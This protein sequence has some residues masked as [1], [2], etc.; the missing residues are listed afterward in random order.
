MTDHS[1]DS[2]HLLAAVVSQLPSAVVVADVAGTVV[3][4]NRQAE[5]L[6][7]HA[8]TDTVGRPVADFAI[9]PRDKD[10]PGAIVRAVLTDGSWSGA[11]DTVHA[12]G[13]GIRV[14]A[15]IAGLTDEASGFRGFTSVSAAVTALAPLDGQVARETPHDP[16]TGLPN[17][18]LF[19]DHIE[20]ALAR[21]AR[22]GQATA[23][24]VIDLDDFKDI[25]DR[26]GS[27]AA[28]RVLQQVGEV[29]VAE[30]RTGDIVARLGGDE[31]FV[32]CDGLA[33]P[34]EALHI[35]ERIQTAL[36]E[37]VDVQGS[38]P[39]LSTSVGVAASARGVRPEGM[40]RNAFAAMYSAKDV[41]RGEVALF[42]HA[43][44]EASRLRNQEVAELRAALLAGDVKTYYQPQVSLATG[45]I[46]GFEALARWTH[47]D[48][49][50]IPP[51]EFIA[52]AE[53][54]G[55]IDELGAQVLRAACAAAAAWDDASDE[56]VQVAVNVS[57]RQLLDPAFPETVRRSIH[58]A[59]IAP[60]LVSLEITESALVDDEVAAVAVEELKS[61]GVELALDDFGT[62]FSS[63]SRLHRY[64]LDWVK[65][66]RCF[67]D[68]I[69]TR[70]ED[71]TIAAAVVRLSQAL[72]L[73]AVGEGVENV[74]QLD[75]L[76]A[77]GCDVGQGFLWSGA[78]SA[79]VASRMVLVTRDVRTPAETVDRL[80]MLAH[81][82]RARRAPRP[83][84]CD[85]DEEVVAAVADRFTA[86]AGAGHALVLVATP[87]HR[88][89]VDLEL[90]RRG[91]VL[92]PDGF[93]ALDAATTLASLIVDDEPDA[94]QFSNV[95]GGLVSDLTARW[96]GVSIYGEMVGIL[97]ERGDALAAIRL[98][99]HWNDLAA[100]LDF[101]LLCG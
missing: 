75:R 38:F 6:Y 70:T 78:V 39:D 55:L 31:F 47:A 35:A 89:A 81:P 86:A 83:R 3:F 79:E 91:V 65:I 28:D 98:E 16:L 59:G 21:S 41:G 33:G 56:P 23:V 15:T 34:A 74:A 8:A 60:S 54:G 14:A 19:L 46:V 32:C 24:M 88:S 61:I 66:D 71:A 7:G 25:H 4:W 53:D 52:L 43:A 93:H 49:G 84:R 63:L 77:M 64:P 95:I 87:P 73:R 96:P 9:G 10:L 1:N 100:E 92:P 82:A 58:D 37:G 99:R 85:I 44:H 101:S 90:R 67:V 50:A 18:R 17:R 13:S 62:G 29:L 12:D 30:M 40:M 80:A 5:E 42:D 57:A 22:S 45:R 69:A 26:T 11:Y 27:E 20:K 2:R 94:A 48:R 51:S 72:G 36:R 97:W 68:A 76:A